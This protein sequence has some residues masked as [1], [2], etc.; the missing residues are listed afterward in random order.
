MA[1][2]LLHLILLLCSAS[3]F[4]QSVRVYT[5][6]DRLVPEYLDCIRGRNIG[7]V[8]NHTGLLRDGRHLADVLAGRD[9]LKLKALFG[10]EHGVRGTSDAAVVDTVD[11]ATGVPVFSLYGATHKPTARMLEGVDMLLFDIQDVGARFYTYVSTLGL[12]MEAAAEQHIPIVVLDRPNPIRGSSVGGPIVLDSLRSFV[13]Y[14]QLPIRHGMTVGELARFYNGT[15]MLR[16]GMKADLTV[17]PLYG[18]RRDLWFDETDL[19]WV[20][21]SPNMP[22]V[23]TA[24]VYPG[25]CLFEGTNVSEGR[26]TANPFELVGAPWADSRRV[27]GLLTQSGLR[28][29]RFE[30]AVFTPRPLPWSASP[31]HAGEQCRGV[32]VVVTERE[33]FEPEQ[34][35]VWMLWAFRAAHPDKFSWRRATI[36]RLA[37]TPVVREMLDAGKHPADIIRT[38]SAG[39]AEFLTRRREHLL[40]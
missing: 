32:R 36:D 19:R 30:E 34:T 14:G 40:Y 27:V 26:G 12:V 38:W 25:V 6:A 20:K 23:S 3:V 11:A 16:G 22:G 13:A 10:P 35:G 24:T 21:P 4:A 8:T 29:V 5:G 2:R 18:W 1:H 31:K 37:G 15:G 39:L 17:I 33:L 9:D 28:G 7:L